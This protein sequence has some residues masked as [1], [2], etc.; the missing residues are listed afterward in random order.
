MKEK[1]IQ[2]NLDTLGNRVSQLS[3]ENR[4]YKLKND[5][6]RELFIQ[7]KTIIDNDDWLNLYES[8]E[9]M[10]VKDIMKEWGKHF[11]PKNYKF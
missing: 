4:L 2:K 5:S 3:E 9:N 10:F 8:C 1:D 6:A 7:I 11:F